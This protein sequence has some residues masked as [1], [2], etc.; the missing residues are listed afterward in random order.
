MADGSRFPHLALPFAIVGASGGWLSTE[1]LA[2]PLLGMLRPGKQP[3]AVVCAAIFAAATGALLTYWCVGT[4]YLYEIDTPDPEARAPTDAWPRHAGAVLLAGAASGA[5]VSVLCDTWGGPA[6]GALGGAFCAV[7]F[8]PVCLAV[9]AAARRAQRARLGSIVAGSD[10]RAVWAILALAL[11]LATVEALP[12]WPASAAGEVT[13]PEPALWMALSA[14]LLTLAVLVAD[15]IALRS[16]RRAIAPGLEQRNPCETHAGDADAPRL[17]LGIGEDLLARLA[18]SATAY[19]GRDRTLA[20]VQGS[21]EQATSALRRA[22]LRGA[23]GLVAIG[24]VVGGHMAANTPAADRFHAA[25]LCDQGR[26][27]WCARAAQLS[28]PHEIDKKIRLYERG[29]ARSS[30]PS[31]AAVATIYERGEGVAADRGVARAFRE[32]ACDAGDPPSCRRAAES[33]DPESARQTTLFRR[34]CTLGD[35]PS[36]ERLGRPLFSRYKGD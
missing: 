3:S 4:R 35:Q 1:L 9:L 19:R 7:A 6:L 18:R 16:A 21:P 28:R 27:A 2:D 29:C 25:L 36:C 12:S 26:G 5:S 34:A 13:R 17:D 32:H 15:V 10:R 11:A 33:M 8:V 30:A 24:A 23:L 14:G 31:C 22:V 20:L